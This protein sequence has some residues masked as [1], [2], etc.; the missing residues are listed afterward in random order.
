MIHLILYMDVKEVVYGL[1]NVIGRNVILKIKSK[2][3]TEDQIAERACF[4]MHRR[5]EKHMNGWIAL[6]VAEQDIICTKFTNILYSYKMEG[7]HSKVLYYTIDKINELCV[8]Y[9]KSRLHIN[10]Y[11]LFQN[12]NI[13]EQQDE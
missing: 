5:F 3:E 1:S 7:M 10:I 13:L 9:L 6:S 8:E 11:G 4:Y 12:I 2:T